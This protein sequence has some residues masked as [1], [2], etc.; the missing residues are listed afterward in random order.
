[1]SNCRTYLNVPYHEKNHAK[2][3]GAKWDA[4]VRKW[5]GREPELIQRWGRDLK[6]N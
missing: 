1:M 2:S 6:K 3:L 4:R 5:Y